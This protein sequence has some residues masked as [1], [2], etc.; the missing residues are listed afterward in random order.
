MSTRAAVYDAAVTRWVAVSLVLVLSLLTFETGLH[1]VHHLGHL[2]EPEKGCVFAS[3]RA[4][5]ELVGSD[6]VMPPLLS[7]TPVAVVVE[8]EP[9]RRPVRVRSLPQE[10]APPLALI[11]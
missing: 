7:L 5:V 10:R 1:S 2:N 11:G 3:A 4:H 6:A 8:S 9:V